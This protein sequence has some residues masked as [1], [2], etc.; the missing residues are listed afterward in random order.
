M[1]PTLVFNFSVA[2]SEAVPKLAQACRQ[3]LNGMGV[4]MATPPAMYGGPCHAIVA[5]APGLPASLPR[6]PART[7]AARR[8][9]AW[10]EQRPSVDRLGAPGL[11]TSRLP[12]VQ[13]RPSRYCRGGRRKQSRTR[14]PTR[15]FSS[16]LRRA[17]S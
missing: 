5:P 1:Y 15:S 8:R 7:P 3:T 4:L 10:T 12:C 17:L 11:R 2:E 6:E 16:T 14:E 13:T 9:C